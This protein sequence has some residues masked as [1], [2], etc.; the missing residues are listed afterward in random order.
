MSELGKNE[1]LN[2]H[3]HGDGESVSKRG[4]ELWGREP[5][6]GFW[7]QIADGSNTDEEVTGFKA[8]YAAVGWTSLRKSN[9]FHT[10]RSNRSEPVPLTEKMVELAYVAAADVLHGTS[11][12]IGAGELDRVVRAALTAALQVKP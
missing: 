8:T 10:H 11:A 1:A 7:V 3:L 6:T 2:Q 12:D 5:E 9:P 4:P